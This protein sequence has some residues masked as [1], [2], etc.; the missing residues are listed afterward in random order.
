MIKYIEDKQ[1]K[2]QICEKVLRDLPEWFGIEE[3]I[4]EYIKAVKNQVFIAY[5]VED[6]VG[7]VSLEETSAIS[8]DMH[9][10][11]VLKDYH[12]RGFGKLLLQEAEN[13]AIS[14]HKAYMT[15]KTLSSQHPDLNYKK[16]REFYEKMAYKALE[17]FPTLWGEA[18][19]CLYMIKNLTLG[20]YT[21]NDHLRLRKIVRS[22]Y[23]SALTWYADPKILY[24]SEGR[25]SPY[26]LREVTRMYD[27]L[28]NI[29]SVFFI[30][31]F[32]AFWKPIGDVTLSEMTMPIVI[33]SHYTNRG[34]GKEVILYLLDIAKEKGFKQISLK[35]IYLYN[36]VSQN[37][38][39]SCGFVE[40]NRDERYVY[41]ERKI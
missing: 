16:T 11:G 8:M 5:Y 24:F 37:L 35:G 1:L 25:E 34:I 10:L 29:G 39:K 15:V 41:L 6:Y 20:V 13:Y 14:R 19:P 26:T 23:Q 9:V 4:V 38:F 18:N 17:E 22:D 30:E 2:T 36:D 28:E 12:G 33:D 3:S 40:T 21:I 32:E 27:Y 7:F 31:Y